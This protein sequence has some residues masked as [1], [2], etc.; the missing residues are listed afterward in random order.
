MKDA[1]AQLTQC[2]DERTAT[3]TERE[4]TIE[5]LEQDLDQTRQKTTGELTEE[6]QARLASEQRLAELQER[7]V[8]QSEKISG[9]AIGPE[10]LA[11][12]RQADGQILTAV[13]G[14]D[15]VYINLGAKNTLTLGLHFAV[16]AADTGIPADGKGKAQVEVATI[17]P[18][19]AE[20]KILWK[21]PN[22]LLMEGDL[23]ANPIYDPSKPPTF[24]VLGEFDLNK[25]GAMDRNGAANVEALI[26]NWGGK[27][28][29]ELT[30]MTD[31]IVLGAP[32]RKPRPNAPP[33]PNEWENYNQTV[34]TART[35]SIP[36]MTQNVFLNFLGYSG[37]GRT[38]SRF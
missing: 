12:A 2:L 32:P 16:Y 21:A 5:R 19:S 27:V 20:C 35:M 8:A 31:F 29:K 24:L 37:N 36:V 6:R 10:Q 30:P 18:T 9:S 22:A 7:F 11:T 14:E 1:A 23:I 15:V 4:K 17:F 25:D 38:A 34:E 3:R 13:P 26:S 33:G 28:S